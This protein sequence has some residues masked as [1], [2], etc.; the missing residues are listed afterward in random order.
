VLLP[1]KKRNFGSNG[2]ESAPGSVLISGSAGQVAIQVSA[3]LGAAQRGTRDAR[4]RHHGQI[5]AL[6]YLNDRADG[7]KKREGFRGGP[8]YGR[9]GRD[10]SWFG[11]DESTD[12]GNGT[13]LLSIQRKTPDALQN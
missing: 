12:E 1:S 6:E 10:R 4:G 3:E 13:C 7:G 5:D 11:R 8:K 2:R 9:G